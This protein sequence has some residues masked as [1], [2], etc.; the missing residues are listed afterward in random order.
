VEL[1]YKSERKELDQSF[2]VKREHVP[3]HEGNWHYHEEYELI[4]ILRGEGLRIVGDS[5]SNFGPPQL[6]LVGPW[7]PHLWKNVESPEDDVSV[8][9]IIVK[10][11]QLLSGWDIFSLP[12]FEGIFNLL[13]LSKQGLIFG[14]NTIAL[15]HQILF[16]LSKA[17]GAEKIIHLLNVLKILS[18]S[19]DFETISSPDFM[20][21]TT[22]L[23]ENRLSRIIN[24][25]SNNF[26]KE[27]SLDELALEAAMTPSSL[28]RFFKNRTNKTIFQFINEFRISK[29]CQMLIPGNKSVS[30][31][32]FESGFNSLTTFNRVFKELK[33]NTPREYK[34]KYRILNS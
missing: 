4:Y 20:I 1:K 32:C 26:T 16:D 7:L 3:H 19:E 14:E 27:I 9:L 5:L 2:Y 21:P 12:E 8:D 25:I 15:V 22:V 11:N 34:E 6:A 18:E 33:K 23:G 30:E 31:I 28:C 29:A 10:F 17:E 13:K 24:F